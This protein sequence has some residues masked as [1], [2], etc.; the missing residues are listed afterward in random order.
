M[1]S[2]GCQKSGPTTVLNCMSG[3]TPLSQSLLRTPLGILLLA[4][5]LAL[6]WSQALP[7]AAT[8][9]RSRH[10]PQ[11]LPAHHLRL[12]D[13]QGGTGRELGATLYLSMDDVLEV[14]VQPDD[15]VEGETRA[16]AYLVQGGR[17]VP[18]PISLQ[19]ASSGAF[20]LR[21]QLRRLPGLNEGR[22][23]ILV[24]IARPW[25]TTSSPHCSL[26]NPS[27]VRLLWGR[28]DITR[29]HKG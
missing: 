4:V 26:D 22:W 9:L 28:L 14:L 23:D 20:L 18:W 16:D 19:R 27:A 12:S 6:L 8:F 21:E 11:T 29:S 1:S 5:P 3:N 24:R 13:G 7:A 10:L 17:V 2:P 15:R 25:E